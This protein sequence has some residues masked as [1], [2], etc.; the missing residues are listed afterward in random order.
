MRSTFLAGP[1]AVVAGAVVSASV[2]VD[3]PSAVMWPV[4]LIAGGGVAA[5]TKGGAALVRAKTGVATG[6]LGNPVVST[7][8][9]FGATALTLLALALPLL[10]LA[11]VALMVVWV[12]RKA[13]RFFSRTGASVDP[14]DSADRHR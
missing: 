1:A 5:V 3:V 4:A 9:T 13:S 6:G 12:L 11:G 10:C 14:A 7:V 8:E 2:M